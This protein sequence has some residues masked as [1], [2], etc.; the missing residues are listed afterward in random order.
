MASHNSEI[1]PFLKKLGHEPASHK[2]MNHFI[3]I[4]FKTASFYLRN[5]YRNVRR[6]LLN[7]GLSFTD[8][9]IDTVSSIFAEKS[10]DGWKLLKSS[11]EKWYPPIQTETE[12]K[13]FLNSVFAKVVNQQVI[14]LLRTT[15][16]LYGMIFNSIKHIIRKNKL[17]KVY[18]SGVLYIIDNNKEG[19]DHNVINSEDFEHLPSELFKDRNALFQNIFDYLACETDYCPAVPLTALILRIKYFYA[20]SETSNNI[21]TSLAE[22][23]EINESIELALK[24]ANKKLNNYYLANNKIAPEEVDWMLKSLKDILLDIKHGGMSQSLF[25]YVKYYIPSLTQDEYSSKYRHI[26]EYLIKLM[27]HTLRRELSRK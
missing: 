17:K 4:C 15:D 9:S 13:F 3:E 18:Q 5:S 19:F 26:L 24:T 6:H 7:N 10:I 11:F 20:H 14:E 22:L 8:L 27:K 1:L 16:P 23:I 2:E 21:S 25:R 12:A